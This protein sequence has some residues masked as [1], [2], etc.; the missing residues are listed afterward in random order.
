MILVSSL[1]ESLSAVVVGIRL[2]VIDLLGLFPAI[3]RAVSGLFS[4]FVSE[5][6]S[7]KL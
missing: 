7:N 4:G 1:F 2:C 3:F 6:V 5:I